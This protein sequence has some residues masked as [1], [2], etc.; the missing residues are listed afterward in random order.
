MPGVRR[1]RLVGES[2]YDVVRC[3]CMHVYL[4]GLLQRMAGSAANGTI[5]GL[6]VHGPDAGRESIIDFSGPSLKFPATPRPDTR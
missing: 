5:A 3:A 6:K 4:R 1:A 2:S